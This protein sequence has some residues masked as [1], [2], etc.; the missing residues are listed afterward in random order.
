MIKE[1][2]KDQIIEFLKSQL[3]RIL[4]YRICWDDRI[5]EEEFEYDTY[6]MCPECDY[7]WNEHI[8]VSDNT[9]KILATAVKTSAIDKLKDIAEKAL[10]EVTF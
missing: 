10:N 3:K 6:C 5:G 9:K 8:S 4:E 2:N 7:E 1:E